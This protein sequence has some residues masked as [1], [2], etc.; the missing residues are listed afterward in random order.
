MK[1]A[2]QICFLWSL[3]RQSTLDIWNSQ[4]DQKT[5]RVIKS[6][7]YREVVYLRCLPKH[8]FEIHESSTYRVFEISSDNCMS[9]NKNLNRQVNFF[10]IT[11]KVHDVFLADLV[12]ELPDMHSFKDKSLSETSL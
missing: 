7:K 10:K 1:L 3:L 11:F 9:K 12:S 4:G 5:V 2:Y 8:L 6:L